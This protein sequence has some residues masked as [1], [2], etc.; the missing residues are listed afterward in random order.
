M[1]RGIKSAWSKVSEQES[2]L[3]TSE[4]LK[5]ELSIAVT[6]PVTISP[7]KHARNLHSTKSSHVL[8][9]SAVETGLLS[10]VQR[11]LDETRLQELKETKKVLFFFFF[12]KNLKDSSLSRNPD[13]ASHDSEPDLVGSS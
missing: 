11:E 8:E 2:Q 1:G 7:Q 6:P 9:I 10:P 4:Q 13:P 5:W 12:T 3:S